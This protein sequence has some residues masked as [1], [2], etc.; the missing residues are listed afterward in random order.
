MPPEL[1]DEAF[2][3]AVQVQLLRIIQEALTN[4]R[5]HAHA[6][7]V[8][9]KFAS[10]RATV[11]PRWS[12]DDGQGFDPGR[13]EVAE[14]G[15]LRAA[16]HARAGGGGGRHRGG[17][18]PRPSG[19]VVT[20]V[21]RQITRAG[22]RERS[23][24]RVLIVDDHPLFRDGLKN[25]LTARGVEVVGTARTGWRRWRRPAPCVRTWS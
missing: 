7:H 24:M 8:Q 18:R 21:P 9:V 13:L 4:V 25:L 20:R 22:S 19:R 10:T 2:G 11:R 15:A 14:G 12:S 23:D 1:S 17:R 16:L 6:S 5:K 3:P